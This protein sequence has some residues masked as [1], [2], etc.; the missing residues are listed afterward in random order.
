M[1]ILKRVLP[2]SSQVLS[3]ACR[4]HAQ[5]ALDAA[6]LTKFLAAALAARQQIQVVQRDDDLAASQ[7]LLQISEAIERIVGEKLLPEPRRAVVD[8]GFGEG[9][10]MVHALLV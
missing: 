5:I 10:A 9:A 4:P 1:A 7:E 8:S 3:L 6:E 2:A